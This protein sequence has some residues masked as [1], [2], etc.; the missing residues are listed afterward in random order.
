MLPTNWVL[1]VISCFVICILLMFCSEFVYTVA[2]QGSGV[3]SESHIPKPADE[4]PN[5][6]TL[7]LRWT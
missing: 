6:K 4:C 1:S 5:Y 7:A 3:S 2:R